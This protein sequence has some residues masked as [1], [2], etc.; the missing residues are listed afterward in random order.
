MNNISVAV[1]VALVL[2]GSF[3][4]QSDAADYY[5]PKYG[6]PRRYGGGNYNRYGRRYG[7]YKGWNNGWKRGRW[8]R[9]YY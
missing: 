4:V 5:G 9:K 6:P 7:G 2:I 3:A 8:G 1:L